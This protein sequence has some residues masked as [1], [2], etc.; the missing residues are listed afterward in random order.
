M[1]QSMS[2]RLSE[3]ATARTADEVM[4]FDMRQLK[5]GLRMGRVTSWTQFKDLWNTVMSS[6][7]FAMVHKSRTPEERNELVSLLQELQTRM[8]RMEILSSSSGD[9]LPWEAKKLFILQVNE[10][11]EHGRL[12]QEQF[13]KDLKDLQ[14]LGSM[15]GGSSSFASVYSSDDDVASASRKRR[16]RDVNRGGEGG[17]EKRCFKCG[18]FKHLQRDCTR[19]SSSSEKK[20]KTATKTKRACFVCGSEDHMADRCPDKKGP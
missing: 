5:D 18:S 7:R 8:Q 1:K 3:L 19:S 4:T 9:K 10:W 11:H 12:S 15:H 14:M 2:D 17:R 6:V 13:R 16:T 20:A